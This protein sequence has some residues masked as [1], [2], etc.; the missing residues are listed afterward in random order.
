MKSRATLSVTTSVRAERA[1]RLV[2]VYCTDV[3]TG[4]LGVSFEVSER[5]ETWDGG[6]AYFVL[7]AAL[8]GAGEVR[9]FLS[10]EHVQ[11]LADKIRAAGVRASSEVE[12][13]EGYVSAQP[14]AQPETVDG[15]STRT[16][17]PLTVEER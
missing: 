11:D 8:A 5:N 15:N 4:M 2:D 13:P 3:E 10:P 1:S 16:Q 7:R 14:E 17:N 12:L 6:R 9:F